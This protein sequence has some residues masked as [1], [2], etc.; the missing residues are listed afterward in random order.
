M[1]RELPCSNCKL[2]KLCTQ[3]AELHDKLIL[4]YISCGDYSPLNIIREDHKFPYEV[5]PVRG[6]ENYGDKEK[7]GAEKAEALKKAEELY[8]NQ[9]LRHGKGEELELPLKAR[10]NEVRTSILQ[11]LQML[12]RLLG[13]E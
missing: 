13:D 8:N 6:V 9:S 10:L 2:Y 4:G 12:E 11:L 7:F 3:S 1:P 5:Y